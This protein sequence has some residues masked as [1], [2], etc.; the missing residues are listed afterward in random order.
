MSATEKNTKRA[1]HV[2]ACD[3]QSIETPS[4]TEQLIYELNEQEAIMRLAG[5]L[6]EHGLG[7][8][9]MPLAL[10]P[11]EVRAGAKGPQ[12]WVD[13]SEPEVI[14]LG[15]TASTKLADALLAGS[16]ALAV[17]GGFPTPDEHPEAGILIEGF[18]AQ[19][20]ASL[21]GGEFAVGQLRAL[22][23]RLVESRLRG[24]GHDPARFA[25]AAWP[26]LSVLSVSERERLREQLTRVD[27]QIDERLSQLELRFGFR[28]AVT[29]TEAKGELGLK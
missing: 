14:R 29:A 18:A 13:P 24:G 4:R 19:Q 11:A 7:L 22:Q 6:A 12:V 8:R 9:L 5:E 23:R 16:R 25:E 15:V 20:T 27:P 26:L 1:G 10:A 28:A 2:R 21:I 17:A 3:A